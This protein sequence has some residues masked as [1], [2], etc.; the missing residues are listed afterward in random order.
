MAFQ[1]FLLLLFKVVSSAAVSA[2]AHGMPQAHLSCPGPLTHT[3]CTTFLFASSFEPLCGRMSLRTRTRR[4]LHPQPS[5]GLAQLLNTV[6]RFYNRGLDIWNQNQADPHTEGKHPSQPCWPRDLDMCHASNSTLHRRQLATPPQTSMDPRSKIST[7]ALLLHKGESQTHRASSCTSCPPPCNLSKG[8]PAHVAPPAWVRRLV[9]LGPP[10]LAGPKVQARRPDQVRTPAQEGPA[11]QMGPVAL[12]MPPAQVGPTAHVG[13]FSQAG[14][15]A[16]VGPPSLAGPMAPT[17]TA[18]QVMGPLDQATTPADARLPAQEGPAYQVGPPL[19][20]SPPAQICPSPQARLPT[21]VG[22]PAHLVPPAQSGPPAQVGP[23]PQVWPP[24]QAGTAGPVKIPAQAEPTCQARP[25][26]QTGT[27]AMTETLWSQLGFGNIE[28]LLLLLTRCA[29][30]LL[31]SFWTFISCREIKDY[32]EF[33]QE[34]LAELGKGLKMMGKALG[35]LEKTLNTEREHKKHLS[36][37]L[38]ELKA[39]LR[40]SE[41]ETERWK[42]LFFLLSRAQH[43]LKAFPED[44]KG[45]CAQVEQGP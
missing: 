24:A 19:Q 25:T 30:V 8:S 11:A 37:E 9:Q 14:A 33:Q 2:P 16:Q 34:Q 40:I 15:T 38:S 27:P 41:K 13:M 4:L 23:T 35:E 42:K 7:L 31:F 20:S 45:H 36:K 28:S 26:A 18:A 22:T 12:V 6:L 5:S 29:L 44:A 21:Q 1:L 32:R 43:L 17:G 3:W 10:V 39:E